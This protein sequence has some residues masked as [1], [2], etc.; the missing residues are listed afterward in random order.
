MA[1]NG[2]KLSKEEQD[3]VY[4]ALVASNSNLAKANLQGISVD[5]K[6]RTENQKKFINLIKEKEI[7]IASGVPGTGKTY[8]ACAEALK[9]L[10][11]GKY[12]KIV[13]IKSVTTL[14]GEAI[15]WLKGTMEEKMLPFMF[16]FR[17]NF[18][19]LIG[20]TM[21]DMLEVA[22]MIEVLP[23]AY[24]RGMSIDNSI[25]IS[26]ESQNI[27]TDNMRSIMTRIG[28]NSKLILIGDTKQ[29]DTKGS[30]SL[31]VIMDAFKDRPE[32]GLM[33]F[34]QAD[35]VRNPIINVIEDVFDKIKLEY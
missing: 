17:N 29:V 3:E 12:R 13:L 5:L 35:Q 22:G 6:C 20:K 7:V 34:E 30:S 31:S 26:D 23:L 21:T 28:E 14:D 1:K 27:S 25:I 10:K 11:A 33:V 8:L 16:S 24:I 15:G 2:R 9:L 32:F 18:H 4:A 19:K